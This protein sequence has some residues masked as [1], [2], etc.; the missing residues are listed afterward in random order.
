MSEK[1][2]DDEIL[3]AF[4]DG[5]L[6]E[7]RSLALE[8]A[9]EQ[10]DALAERLADFL[11]SRALV[12]DALK[13]LIN[14]PIPEALAAKVAEIAQA[15][16]LKTAE[17]PEVLAFTPKKITPTRNVS[18]WVLPLAASLIAVISGIAG[19]SIGQIG[20]ENTGFDQSIASALDRETSGQDITLA[21]S[22]KVLN[23]IA[24]FRDESGAV[25]REYE[26]KDAATNTLSISCQ[27]NGG[28]ATRLALTLPTTEGYAPASSHET[29][30]AY[31]TSINAGAPLSKEE[32][33][34]VLKR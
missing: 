28:W 14:E 15:S 16:T 9:L 31:L 32:E 26:V 11:D 30:S 29:V 17:P 25:C 7:E 27:E 6:D 21:G 4:A 19:F 18:S 13:P 33:P 2:F 3:M 10:D 23:I 22:R 34:A 12:S 1:Q 24:T 8:R 5:E 20:S